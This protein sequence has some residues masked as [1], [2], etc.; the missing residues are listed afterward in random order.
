M[1]TGVALD[2]R[3][4][5]ADGGRVSVSQQRMKAEA[6]NQRPVIL[7]HVPCR[8]AG[9]GADRD[10]GGVENPDRDGAAARLHDAS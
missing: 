1:N 9:G 10:A 5:V 4:V 8:T 7:C 3:R 2:A 6:A